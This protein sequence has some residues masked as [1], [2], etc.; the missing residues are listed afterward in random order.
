[1]VAGSLRGTDGAGVSNY[2]ELVAMDVALRTRLD[3]WASA[4]HQAVDMAEGYSYLA[5]LAVEEGDKEEAIRCSELALEW[6]KKL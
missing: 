6:A 3:Q 1:V 2:E 4:A 5:K